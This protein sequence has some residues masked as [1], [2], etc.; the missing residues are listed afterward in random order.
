M[1]TKHLH[2]G[3]CNELGQ[4]TLIAAV[5]GRHDV[6]DWPAVERHADLLAI[7]HGVQRLAQ[8]LLQLARA[9]TA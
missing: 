5:A 3:L 6:C 2:G 8:G 1:W 9:G 4:Q 7:S